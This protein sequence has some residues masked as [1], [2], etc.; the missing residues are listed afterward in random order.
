MG[1]FASLCRN[2][3]LMIHHVAHPNEKTERH[4]LK[5]T[6]EQEKRGSVT[7]RRTTIEEVEIK[8]QK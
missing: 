6:M 7:L 2:V 1:L 8:N 3:G 5:R 4:E